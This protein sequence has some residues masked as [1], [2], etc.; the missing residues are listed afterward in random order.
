M[1][2]TT[3]QTALAKVRAA[4]A[5]GKKAPLEIPTALQ[6]GQI[7]VVEAVFQRRGP[8]IDYT[9]AAFIDELAREVK[10][11]GSARHLAPVVVWWCGAWFLVDGHH[12]MAAVRKALDT[13]AVVPVVVFGGSLEAALGAS[14]GLNRKTKLAMTTGE[15]VNAAWFL[16]VNAPGM[17]K[18]E[19]MEATGVS[20]GI[21]GTQRRVLRVLQ[22]RQQAGDGLSALQRDPATLSWREAIASA[23]GKA[24]PAWDAEGGMRA[25]VE[26]ITRRMGQCGLGKDIAKN[27]E[28]FLAALRQ[29][30]PSLDLRDWEG[31]ALE[32]EPISTG[33]SA[34]AW[35]YVKGVKVGEA[36]QR[37]EVA[38][39]K[40]I[41]EIRK[42]LLAESRKDGVSNDAA[43]A[44]LRAAGGPALDALA[45]GA[46]LPKATAGP[47]ADEPKEEA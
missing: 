29:V 43:A 30:A 41:R 22:Q 13:S 11:T 6:W 24:L 44:L 46:K 33:S 2:K 45:A 38:Q 47:A 9:R 18:P 37:E 31:D 32:V 17:S 25:A 28:A 27:P 1:T 23:E 26:S 42:A 15:R 34:P 16:T 19:V 4:E 8:A 20:D 10:R 39:E 3:T 5:R 7:K 40:R 36:L 14:I 35:H 12:R 21:V